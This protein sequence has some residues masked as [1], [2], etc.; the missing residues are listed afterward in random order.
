MATYQNYIFANLGDFGT[1]F[2]LDF[3]SIHA[4]ARRCLYISDIGSN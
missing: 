4:A 3:V 2:E 1:I